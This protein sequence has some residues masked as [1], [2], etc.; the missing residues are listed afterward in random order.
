MKDGGLLFL[1]HIRSIVLRIDDE[2]ISRIRILEEGSDLH[3]RHELPA[4]FKQLYVPQTP[5]A[6]RQ[7]VFKSLNLQIEFS[8][9][10]GS[11][12]QSYL[13]QHTMMMSSGDIDL[14]DWA[15]QRKLFP[16][17]AVAVLLDVC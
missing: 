7:D 14:D 11:F 12:V 16:W 5:P 10:T 6:V 3:V 2:T 4:D 1:K 13:I 9:A 17:T 8:S 15:R